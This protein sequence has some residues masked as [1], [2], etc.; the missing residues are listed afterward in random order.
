MGRARMGFVLFQYVAW[1]DDLLAMVC[2]ALPGEAAAL[3]RHQIARYLCLTCALAW[4]DISVKVSCPSS[5]APIRTLVHFPPMKVR[6][7]FPGVEQVVAAGL[8][9][10]VSLYILSPHRRHY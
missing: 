7:R 1:P 9:T 5:L 2:F 3:K 10:K 6:Q 4:R 8:M